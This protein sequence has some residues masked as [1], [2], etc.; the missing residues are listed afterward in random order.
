MTTF[1]TILLL[2]GIFCGSLPLAAQAHPN[3]I[4][5]N[6]KIFT[7]D[8]RSLRAEAIAI[9]G[10]RI[11]AVGASSKIRQLAGRNTRIVD[12]KG[13][14]VIPGIN[15][16]HFHFAPKPAGIDLQFNTMEP[17]WDSVVSELRSKIR[18]ASKGEWVFGVIGGDAMADARAARE[19]IDRLAPDNPVELETYYGHGQILNSR[20]IALLN[21]SENEP[22]P[23]GGRFEPDKSGR[24]NGRVWEYAQW[25][26]ART[27][28]E[29]VS[30]QQA[31]E[32]LREMAGQASAFGITSMQIMPTMRIERF[33]KLVQSADL[34][35]RV[36]AIPFS[37]TTTRGRDLSEID[38]LGKIRPAVRT[39]ASGIKWILDGTPFEHGA[40][41]RQP[42]NDRPG[43]SGRL[44]F[45]ETE[46][47]KMVKE[48][49]AR[50]QQ[51]LIH[52]AGN[53][54]I[55][56]LFDAM[57]RER[58]RDWKPL[59]WRIE[60]GDA[61]TADFFAEAKR[62]GVVVVQNPTHLSLVG[63]LYSR[64][65]RQTN[66]FQLR[67]LIDAGIPLALGSDGPMNPYL[68]IMLA[69][70]N[71]VRPTES[72]TREQAVRAYTSG[73]AYAE[74][75]DADKGTLVKGKVADISVLSD[76]IFTMPPAEMPKTRSILTIL[77]GKVVHD[78]KVLR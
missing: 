72:I 61:L 69:S 47:P 1:R 8:I 11:V 74:F 76:D 42:Y 35:I 44:E 51:L 28:S 56:G 59:R 17:S 29:M 65:G 54:P 50:K 26:I 70:I 20:A 16:A 58:G 19:D 75:A 14:T 23:L 78:E 49:L 32:M 34:P 25:R 36:R 6:G 77:G 41:L 39:N 4:L 10:E 37:L 24:M 55:E 52:A 43:F 57:K 30:D 33:V 63:M 7:S 38:A 3:L 62:L 64:Y 53:R 66:F 13:R 2:F 73:S 9:S 46:V 48:A 22:D 40:A 68:N 5:V 45:P 21:I 15:D 12:L 18:T 60:H 67:S 31:I 71:P 27:F